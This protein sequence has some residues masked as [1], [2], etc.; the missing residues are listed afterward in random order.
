MTEIEVVKRV[1]C[2]R[3][4][5]DSRRLRSGNYNEDHIRA[6]ED[7][8]N[9]VAGLP[10]AVWAPHSAT[11]SQI[12]AMAKQAKVTGG[13]S[14]LIIDYIGLIRPD[15]H[16]LPRHEQV[17][18]ISRGL[19]G[20]AKELQIPI[21]TLCQLGRE[22][23]SDPPKLSH[24]RDSG[25]IEQDADIVLLLHRIRGQSDA[26]LIIAKHRHGEVGQL[27]LKWNRA[28]MAYEDASP[29]ARF[30]GS[31]QQHFDL[32]GEGSSF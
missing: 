24:L 9:N 30:D 5:V 8:V 7:E 17:A 16:R 22:A 15:D 23:E 4:R 29:E 10:I 13:L 21:L 20:L 14:L 32:Q 27:P 19:K 28:R 25:A 1:L 18:R 2:G 26:Q 12:R 3:S 31:S 11:L 6:I